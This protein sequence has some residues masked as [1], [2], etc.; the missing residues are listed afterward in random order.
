[1]RAGTLPGTVVF[2]RFPEQ[3]FVDGAKNLIRQ[4]ERPNPLAFQ[5]HYINLCHKFCPCRDAAC[6]AST[7]YFFLPAAAFFAAFSG[8]IVVAPA[9]P[10]R[11]RGGCLARLI[12]TYPPFGPG[13]AP[14]TTSKLS[15][16]SIPSTRRLRTVTRS[17]P[18]WPDMRMPLNTRDGKAE[19][20][21]DPVI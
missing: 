10:R 3:V 16:L 4:V 6:H 5:I 11:S 19:E 20:P 8:S 17:V 12:T 1:M 15:S 21:I 2:H 18:M 9:N 13:T 14:S 7:A